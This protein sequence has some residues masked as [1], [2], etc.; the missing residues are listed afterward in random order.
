[1]IIRGLKV[2]PV[3]AF[4]YNVFSSKRNAH[5]QVFESLPPLLSLK[6]S[7]SAPPTHFDITLVSNVRV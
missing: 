3:A 5:C 2:D 6:L 1:M 4:Q 7:S